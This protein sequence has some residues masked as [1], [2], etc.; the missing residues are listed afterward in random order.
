MVPAIEINNV[1][2]WF[3]DFQA[4]KN[5][6]LTTSQGDSAEPPEKQLDRNIDENLQSNCFSGGIYKA[7]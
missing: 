7:T 1:S 3:D 5:V 4:L 6:S 2:K